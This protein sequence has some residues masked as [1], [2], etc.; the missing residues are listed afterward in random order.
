[1][2][3]AISLAPLYLF[4]IGLVAAAP[5]LE[6][7]AT[8]PGAREPAQRW[9][10]IAGL[11]AIGILTNYLLVLLL[12]S[13]PVALAVGSILA[14]VGLAL[15]VR[16][17]IRSRA[18]ER[19]PG[20]T[21][22]SW[23]WVF[24]LLVATIVFL[25]AV[26]ILT[27]PLTHWDAR[28]IW[29]FQAKIIYFAGALTSD[30]PWSTLE[31]AHGDYPKLLPTLAAQ[32]AAVAGFWNETLPKSALLALLVPAALGAISF[33]NRP[34]SAAFLIAMLF[35]PTYSVLWNGYADGYLALYSVLCV[36]ALGRWIEQRN[37]G[38]LLLGLAALGIAASLKNEGLYFLLCAAVGSAIAATTARGNS[39]AHTDSRPSGLPAVAWIAAVSLAGP[40]TWGITK[41]AWG[42]TNDLGLSDETIAII[43]GRLSEPDA[44]TSIL[45]ALFQTFELVGAI[46][47]LALALVAATLFRVRIPTAFWLAFTTAAL[48]LAGI[49]GVYLATPYE[50]AWH[51]ETSA[52]RTVLP[53]FAIFSGAT[54]L[55]LDVIERPAGAARPGGTE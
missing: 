54:F 6:A 18:A 37:P 55:L 43:W 21:S 10:N 26:L 32:V 41:R 48:Y 31:F 5:L 13:L 52:G 29:F 30:S 23:L 51:L 45:N 46:V 12:G 19:S 49:I 20:N 44:L 25:Y 36:L 39:G 47:P 34:V 14:V 8:A 53:I 1:L 9:A 28:S 27:L 4:G 33:A 15:G 35:F 24:A 22:E 50:L 16:T 42:L 40:L 3:A 2:P 7:L 11:F 38:D 17:R